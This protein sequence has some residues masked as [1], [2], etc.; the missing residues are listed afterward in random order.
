[1][2]WKCSKT[3]EYTVRSAYH[4]AK[5]RYEV[6]NGSCSDRDKNKPLWK[7]LWKIGGPSAVKMFL[8]KACSDILPTKEKLFKKHI[9][10][11]PLYPICNLEVEMAGHILWSCPS[12]RDIW[13]KCTIKVQ[14]SPSEA[15]DFMSILELL[16]DRTT[17][18]ELQLAVIVAR[19]IWHKRNVVV[20]GGKFTSP[21]AILRS[22][23]E[24]VEAFSKAE[25]QVVISRIKPRAP[26]PTPW[27]KP[28]MGMVKVN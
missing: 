24:Q 4:L 9:T 15:A 12:A 19:Q 21:T 8:W 18:E 27:Q 14:K 26:V 16:M 5:E 3:G 6:D 20:F 25:A 2:V 7:A 1:M 17:M 11:D 23:V 22:A 10:L 28:P 13:F